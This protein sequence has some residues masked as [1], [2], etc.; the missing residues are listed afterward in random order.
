MVDD[1]N[2]RC[3]HFRYY[4]SDLQI[5]TAEVAEK[6]AA[7]T[8]EGRGVVS[9]WRGS[10]APT[11]AVKDAVPP[12]V[13]APAAP[14]IPLSVSD[15]S[16]VPGPNAPTL[17]D[18]DLLEIETSTNTQ[19]R[20]N[21][22]GYFRGPINGV[23]GPQSRNSL[24]LFKAA[25]DLP[26]DDAYDALTAAR[27]FSMSA[28]KGQPPAKG[29]AAQE[30]TYLPPPG[31]T[32]N[33][34]N[35][36]DAIKIHTKLR[37]LG[38]Y[39]ANNSTLWSAASREALKDFKVRNDLNADD[40]WDAPTEGRLM[41]AKPALATEDIEAGFS[42]TTGGTWSIDA[43]ACPGA[44]GSSD[45]LPMTITQRR[46]VTEGAYCEFSD[47]TGQGTSW[48]VLGTCL[49]NG[50]TRKSNINLIRTGDVLV[51]SSANG[52]TKYFRCSN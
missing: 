19:K 8:A 26:D 9:S 46:A 39:R 21:E 30:S 31:A 14:S 42:A 5:V 20:L 32:L 41:S 1:Y 16:A 23:W 15:D 50:E 36:Q 34:L 35:R 45:A 2:S 18:V 29:A 17:P 6:S 37:E 40:R 51:W 52:T 11:P 10:D 43:R 4:E 25:N 27:L 22:L 12:S 44:A 48:K 3:G 7:L 38:F 28:I 13:S 33:P 24:K 47:I 49:V